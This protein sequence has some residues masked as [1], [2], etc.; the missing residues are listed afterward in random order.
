MVCG[1]G[2]H[3]VRAVPTRPGSAGVPSWPLAAAGAGVTAAS[4]V[5][6]RLV[7]SRP[8]RRADPQA[9]ARAVLHRLRHQRRDAV[10]LRGPRSPPDPAAAAVRAQPHPHAADRPAQLPPL[11]LRRR[12]E[13]E[14]GPQDAGG[15]P[16]PARP[17]PAAGDTGD[18]GPRVHRQRPQ[19]LQLPAGHP[20]LRHPVE[21][22]RGR[23]GHLGGRPAGRRT[24]TPRD[25][26]RRR[27]R[28]AH[29][30]RSRLCRQGRRLR[31][32]TT[33]AAGPQGARR[34]PPRVGDER[35]SAAARPRLPAAPGGPG[36]GRHR[37]HQVARAPSRSRGRR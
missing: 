33:S 6:G 37:Q 24:S 21:A 3:I 14:P 4:A 5:P 12:A 27:G 35:S 32:R 15:Q 18:D 29:R 19:L 11:R 17:A 31:R 2:D 16:E 7:R 36:L 30:P 20:G 8:G 10:G 28:D 13:A 25:Q 9:A 1:H 26:A 22:R 23:R 34:R